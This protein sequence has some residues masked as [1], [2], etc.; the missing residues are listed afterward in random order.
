[1]QKSV[2]KNKILF[3]LVLL[4]LTIA[5]FGILIPSLGFYWD[6][7]PMM[8]FAKSQGPL[9]FPAAFAG[10]RPLL[11]LAYIVTT[12]I[13]KID[14]FQWQLLGMFSRWFVTLAAW[15]SLKQLWP[16]HA[17][18]VGWVALLFA[19]FPGFKQQPISVVYSNGLFPLIS[20]LFSYGLM[21]LA[22][23]NPKKRILFTILGLL[24]YGF[25]LVSTEYYIGLD[26][27]RGVI[28]WLVISENKT[29]IKER[30]KS[31]FFAWLPYLIALGLFL[32]WRVFIFKFPTYQPELLESLTS[33]GQT[34]SPLLQLI[35]RFF[36][37]P[38]TATWTTWTENFHFPVLSDLTTTSMKGYW[39]IVIVLF[40]VSIVYLLFAHFKNENEKTSENKCRW[41][42][43]AMLVGG[44]AIMMAGWPYFITG[45]PIGL[46]YPYDRFMLAFIWGSSIFVVGLINL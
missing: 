15:W 14:P 39:G 37:D 3:P 20:Y 6:D 10:D 25:C 38:F 40:L 1:M 45:L 11:S 46:E 2:L 21:I 16:D 30:L 36:H 32:F 31:T 18:Q 13:L 44:V 34:F 33:S 23:R 24:T 7:W 22:L 8:W 35:Y 28:I 29:S 4:A 5:A 42:L 43:Q 17:E 9:G 19:V 27:V 12:A 41:S 26:I